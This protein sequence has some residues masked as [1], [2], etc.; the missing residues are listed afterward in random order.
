[1]NIFQTIMLDQSKIETS[2]GCPA[3]DH[4][5]IIR[6]Q[7]HFANLTKGK[8]FRTPPKTPRVNAQG[9]TRGQRKRAA[10]ER[11]FNPS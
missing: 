11:A 2:L 3:G 5:A 6:R 7:S 4:L 9:L 1:M 8:G 10:F